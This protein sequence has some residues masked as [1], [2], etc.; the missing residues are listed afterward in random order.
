MK[1]GYTTNMMSEVHVNGLYGE[2]TMHQDFSKTGAL[3]GSKKVVIIIQKQPPEVFFLKNCSKK[4][5]KIHRETPMPES[6]F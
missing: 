5:R 4:F 6:L 3:L 2:N 1:K